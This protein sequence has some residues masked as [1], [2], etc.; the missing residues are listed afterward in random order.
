MGETRVNVR[1]AESSHWYSTSGEALYEIENASKPGTMRGFTLTDA[2]KAEPRPVPSVTTVMRVRANPDIQRYIR[3]M[4]I[5]AAATEPH[6]PGDTTN[7]WVARVVAS[8]DEH[9]AAA[10]QR[11]IDGH[12]ML[13]A[14]LRDGTLPPAEYGAYLPPFLEWMKAA[15][16][17]NWESEKIVVC[18][19]YG[20]RVDFCGDGE[21]VPFTVADAKFRGGK[22]G[23][24]LPRYDDDAMQLAAYGR[25]IGRAHTRLV[26][27]VFSTTEPGR[28]EAHELTAAEAERGW[29]M[30]EACLTLWSLANNYPLPKEE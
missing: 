27:L 20:G 7:A 28:L 16:L 12:D 15:G 29:R 11:G 3:E 6:L 5:A 4:D 14:W 23:K 21:L 13:A 1:T 19:R 24:P 17:D 30:F 22:A 18:N 10:R 9:A 2:R 8:A 25:A 26:S